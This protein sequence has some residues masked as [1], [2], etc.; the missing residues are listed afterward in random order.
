M[1]NKLLKL[2]KKFEKLLP[3]EQKIF[4]FFVMICLFLIFQYL[5]LDPILKKKNNLKLEHTT[6]KNEVFSLKLKLRGMDKA[7]NTLKSLDKEVKDLIARFNSLTSRIPSKDKL[8]SILSHLA[9]SEK[10]KFM[11]KEMDEQTYIENSR[12]T[13][14]PFSIIVA[15]DYFNVL[16]FLISLENA[17]NRLLKINNIRFSRTDLNSMEITA[18]FTVEAYKIRSMEYLIELSKQEAMKKEKEN[19]KNNK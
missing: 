10:V 17:Q 12:Y 14:I 8:A 6:L 5:L 1:R 9:A 4:P 2:E 16:D 11:V 13:V 19:D 3:R 15:G 18:M 7:A